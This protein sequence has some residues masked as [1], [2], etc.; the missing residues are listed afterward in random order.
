MKIPK[1]FLAFGAAM[2][3][4]GGLLVGCD[5]KASINDFVPQ[6]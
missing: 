1:K 4:A 3:I 2:L 6:A 5:Q